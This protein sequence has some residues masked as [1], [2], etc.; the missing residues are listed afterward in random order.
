VGNRI[1]LMT[2][3]T[4]EILPKDFVKKYNKEYYIKKYN[5]EYYLDI[6]SKTEMPEHFDI[7]EDIEKLVKDFECSFLVVELY[8]DGFV[9]VTDLVS[10]KVLSDVCVL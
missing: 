7:K 8:E 5:N 3:S 9:A 1:K 10:K 6:A 4:Q 2:Q